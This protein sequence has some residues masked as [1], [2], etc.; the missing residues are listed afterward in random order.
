ML[1][2]KK[3]NDIKK[4]SENKRNKRKNIVSLALVGYTNAGKSSLFNKLTG[5]KIYVKDE[6]F[7]TLDSTTR[8]VKTKYINKNVVITDTI[9]FIRNLPHRLVDSFHS[10]LLEVLEADLLL[11]VIDFSDE[12]WEEY[13]QNVESVLN[14]MD[15][16]E[17]NIL[18][19]FNKCDKIDEIKFLFE[20]KHIT[21]V[22]PDS[23]FISAK[24]G[25]GIDDLEKKIM[26]FI[27][28]YA[29]TAYVKVPDE[30]QNLLQ[31][32]YKYSEVLERRYDEKLR[33]H[34]LKIRISQELFT[35][36]KKQIDTYRFEKFLSSK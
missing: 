2:K 31:F 18:T 29:K 4:I 35:G 14:E 12:N 10:T 30:M 8:L 27:T 23:V 6:L 16:S 28:E 25:L 5:S 15:I 34:I 7:A 13:A 26:E 11:H 21:K 1:V 36:I 20:K 33:E 32:I 22:Y 9:G 17:K 3:L 19:V 24:S